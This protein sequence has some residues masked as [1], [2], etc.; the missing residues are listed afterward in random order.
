MM[1]Y[2]HSTLPAIGTD[3]SLTQFEKSVIRFSR[4]QEIQVWYTV[5]Y[6]PC[7]IIII[8]VINHRAVKCHESSFV[9]R[10]N[11]ET[12]T[13]TLLDCKSTRLVR[14]WLFERKLIIRDAPTYLD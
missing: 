4:L 12:F 7:R 8:V 13:C 2:R 9:D 10:H 1:V 5:Y 14:T 3:F 11:N 6:K